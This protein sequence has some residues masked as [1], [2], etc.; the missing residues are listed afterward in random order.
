MKKI[1]ITCKGSR[2]VPIEKLE[3]F[4]GNLKE[5]SEKEF[6]KLK[7]SILKYGFSFPVFVWENN[8][9]DG[10]QR[11]MTVLELLKTGE[12]EIDDVPV[13]DI[14]AMDKRE[15]AEKLLVLNS[16]YAA[17][18]YEGLY[19]F[20]TTMEIDFEAVSLNLSLPNID[21][22]K[23]LEGY[24]KDVPPGEDDDNIPDPPKKAK[25]KTGDLYKLGDHRLLCGDSTKIEDVERLMDGQ[26]ADMIFTD[27]PYGVDYDGGSKKRE[28]LTD[29]HVGSDIYEKAIPIM[30][31][32]CDGPCYT[33][34]AGTKPIGL[35]N[36][37]STFG[38]IHALIIWVKN[39]STFN[40]N[41]HYKQKHEPCL[42]WKPK[43]KTLKWAGNNNEDTVWNIDRESKNEFHPTQKPVA[44]A[45]RAI[46]N[47]SIGLVLDLFLGSGST[48]IACEK[49]SRKCYGM[50]LDPIYCD[51]I[52]QRWEEYTG[53]K[54]VS[55]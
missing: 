11:V 42:Y 4:Q 29:D 35:Y 47:H 43:G 15:A 12:Y 10:H 49:T 39:N 55:I 5:L 25:T 45:E 24:V 9:I 53:K 54:A 32:Y 13:V 46:K 6:E 3:R 26:K 1:K 22:E 7:G 51:V 23:F 16:Q 41:I 21:I 19:E 18:T 40:M 27:P 30:A 44:L 34:Y 52:I 37:V 38:D 2:S 50:E 36:S 17:M 20:A 8:I 33:W 31:E 14:E 28:K 48:L